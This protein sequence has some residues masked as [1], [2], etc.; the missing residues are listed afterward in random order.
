MAGEIIAKDTININDVE[1]QYEAH[2]E[3]SGTETQVRLVIVN[4]YGIELYNGVYDD[5]DL[6]EDNADII[7]TD[8]MLEIL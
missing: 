8:R 7:A 1:Y 3:L 5:S 2:K 4:S 6:T